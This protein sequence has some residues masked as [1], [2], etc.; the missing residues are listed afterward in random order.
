MHHDTDR[1]AEI[2]KGYFADLHG[3]KHTH[4]PHTRTQAH[5]LYHFSLSCIEFRRNRGKRTE[6]PDHLCSSKVS[7]SWKLPFLYKI[8]SIKTVSIFS[9]AHYVCTYL[10]IVLTSFL[11]SYEE[12]VMFPTLSGTSLSGQPLSLP[13]H[14]LIALILVSM[15]GLGMVSVRACVR[16][17]CMNCTHHSAR[18]TN[19]VHTWY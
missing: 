3:M 14:G 2:D 4:T 15:R 9:N 6:A 8:T 11:L 12:S 7:V 5:W 10:L 13:P 19:H 18:L 17:S 16:T 1:W